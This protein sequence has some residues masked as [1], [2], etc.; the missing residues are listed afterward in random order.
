MKTFLFIAIIV[1]MLAVMISMLVGFL[2]LSKEGETHR[3]KSNKLMQWRIVL[4]GIAILLMFIFA[5]V[6]T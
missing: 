2:N 1:A 5:A 6:S 3:T 4:Q